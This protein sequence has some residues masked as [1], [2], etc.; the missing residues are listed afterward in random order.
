MKRKTKIAILALMVMFSPLMVTGQGQYNNY[1]QLSQKVIS[2]WKEYPAICAVKSLVRTEGGK[3]IWL[4]SIGTGDRDN[5]PA[6]AILGG[7]EGNY[8]LGRELAAGIAEN[9]LKN[10]TGS[11]VK[12][13]LDKVTFYI[14]PD[15][16]PDASEQLFAG[17]KYERAIN[18]RPTDDDR[19]FATDE[20]P[21][22][23]LNNDGI[24]SLVRVEDPSG[25][26]TVS[27][28]DSRIMVKVDISKG[29]KG[30]YLVISEGTDNDKDGKWNEDGPGGVNFNSNLTYNYK[31]FGAGAGQYPVSEPETR[32]VLDFL[33]D[34]F[35]IYSVFAFGP[36]DNLG[37]P[38]KASERNDRPGSGQQSVSPGGRMRMSRKFTSILPADE[39]VNKLVSDRYH[40]ITGAKGA[41][42]STTPPGNFMEWAYFHYGRYSFST[43]GWW[44]PVEKGKNPEAAFLKF[45][46]KNKINDVFIPWT[47]IKHPDFPGKIA[48]VGGLKPDVMINPPPDTLNTLINKHFE[49]ITS[50][51]A[52]HP[53]LEFAD[54]ETENAGENIYRITLKVHN[55][56]VFATCAEAG[57]PN[58]WTKLMRITIEPSK[59]QTILSGLKVQRIQRLEGDESADFSW[60]ISGKG[61][62]TLT[63]G[64]VNVGTIT[65]KIELK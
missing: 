17:L 13:L 3:E 61:P 24:I 6:I 48:E 25:M 41:P 40:E 52:L 7:I 37:Q 44:F 57:E 2:M 4:I 49:F 11:E 62:L 27:D 32:A 31:A 29:Q 1:R 54:I 8:L 26:Y 59:N 15:V 50:I 43:P 28:E 47:P 14:L 35:N 22:E 64:A 33:F 42:N 39:K 46:A 65:A 45:A 18:A 16:S 53:E 9:I 5:K 38:M 23:D 10:S 51:A 58:M 12:N 55:K 36:Q 21:Y 56:G 60:L 30:K 63:A 20:D 19:D 34:R